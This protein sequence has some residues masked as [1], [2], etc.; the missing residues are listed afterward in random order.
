L[1]QNLVVGDLGE[2]LEELS[3]LLLKM[4]HILAELGHALRNDDKRP[5]QVPEYQFKLISFRKMNKLQM[6]ID[7]RRSQRKINRRNRYR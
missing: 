3:I 1:I 2:A 5:K 4:S 7:K 6:K